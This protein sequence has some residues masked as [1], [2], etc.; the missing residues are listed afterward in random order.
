MLFKHSP[1]FKLFATYANM[2]LKCK[3]IQPTGKNHS[4]TVIFF[5]GSGKYNFKNIFV[6]SVLTD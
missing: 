3:T 1:Y 2:K 5:H 4:A 6:R